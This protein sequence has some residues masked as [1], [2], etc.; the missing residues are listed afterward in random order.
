[1]A[2]SPADMATPW[3][4]IIR[5]TVLRPS[6]VYPAPRRAWNAWQVVHLAATRRL[7]REGTVCFVDVRVETGYDGAT[8]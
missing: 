6:A 4:S 2:S 8:K 1:V 3:L 7:L 5:M